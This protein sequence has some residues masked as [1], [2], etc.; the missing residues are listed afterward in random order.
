MRRMIFDNKWKPGPASAL[1]GRTTALVAGLALAAAAGMYG[2]SVFAEVYDD[3]ESPRRSATLWSGTVWYGMGG[4]TVTNGQVR[5]YVTPYMPGGA[6]S[7]LESRRTW[8]LREGRTLEF[9]TDLLN[10][11]DDG[12]LAYIGFFQNKVRAQMGRRD[13]ALAASLIQMAQEIIEALSAGNS[14]PVGRRTGR[15]IS[16]AS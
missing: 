14:K 1:R 13:P 7:F 5:V 9:R 16:L 10:S 3:F 4:Q 2:T 6:F 8:T 15:F 12:A 11:S